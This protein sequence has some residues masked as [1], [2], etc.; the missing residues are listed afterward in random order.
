MATIF[1]CDL[2]ELDIPGS[3]G[4]TVHCDDTPVDIFLVRQ[5]DTVR[6]YINSCPHTGAPLD[7]MP[8]RFLSLDGEHIQCST[9]HALFRWQDGSCIA[10]P[11]AGDALTPVPL[12]VRAGSVY[13]EQQQ[14]CA[15]FTDRTS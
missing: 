1:L 8:D 11:C 2:A 3:R 7:W 4:L 5:G 14:F 13:L 10:G 6:G 9:H 12:A 15:D